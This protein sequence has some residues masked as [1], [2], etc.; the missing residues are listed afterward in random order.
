MILD[1]LW[2]I[3]FSKKQFGFFTTLADP[4][5]LVWQKTILFPKKKLKPSQQWNGSQARKASLRTPGFDP[6][7][8]TFCLP[9]QPGHLLFVIK[10]AHLLQHCNN[11]II[12]NAKLL[13][14]PRIDTQDNRFSDVWKECKSTWYWGHLHQRSHYFWL[15]FQ[16]LRHCNQLSSNWF[17]Y[18][19]KIWFQF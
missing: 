7:L 5:L 3:L 17:C 4:P 1:T 10:A 12:E 18:F 9:S 2:N 15:F 8:P 16:L 19:Q 13:A 14:V 11:K 6:K